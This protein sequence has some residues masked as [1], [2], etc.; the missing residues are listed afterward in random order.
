MPDHLMTQKFTTQ[1]HWLDFLGE[2][3]KSID[4]DADIGM[5]DFDIQMKSHVLITA[6][7]SWTKGGSLDSKQRYHQV[8]GRLLSQSLD[9]DWINLGLSGWSNTH[10]LMTLEQVIKQ[11]QSTQDYA[12]ISVIMMLTENGREIRNGQSFEFDYGSLL[13]T[14]TIQRFLPE[15]FEQIE[16]NW[17]TKIQSMCEYCDERFDFIL[18]E[19]ACWHERLRQIKHQRVTILDDRWIDML[20]DE[21]KIP[22][23]PRSKISYVWTLTNLESAFA[24]AGVNDTSAAKSSLLDIMQQYELLDDWFKSSR[25]NHPTDKYPNAEA[26]QILANRLLTVMRKQQQDELPI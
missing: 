23:P 24:I 15:L 22:R 21:Q 4:G 18:G 14:A 19:A 2:W 3:K 12:K 7:C 11:L 13:D 20:A 8:F 25:L 9:A 17:I 6:G 1:Q 26:H 5:Y 10:I 16:T